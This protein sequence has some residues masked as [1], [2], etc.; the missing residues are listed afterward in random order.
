M[1]ERRLDRHWKETQAQ[2]AYVRAKQAYCDAALAFAEAV[3]VHGDLQ[4]EA[5][6]AADS[7]FRTARL[8]KDDAWRVLQET[9]FK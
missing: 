6:V 5:V 3:H 8:C 9:M 1:V 2:G 7:A 4:H